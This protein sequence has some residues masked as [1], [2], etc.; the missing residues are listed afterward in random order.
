LFVFA[1]T[2]RQKSIG[3]DSPTAREEGD[4]MAMRGC[5]DVCDTPY[6]GRQECRPSSRAGSPK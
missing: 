2:D 5:R 4:V 6:G 1:E 3:T